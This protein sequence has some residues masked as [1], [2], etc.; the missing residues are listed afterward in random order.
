MKTRQILNPL[1]YPRLAKAYFRHL[2]ALRR[3]LPETRMA[4]AEWPRWVLRRLLSPI[5]RIPFVLTSRSGIRH[6]LGDDVVDD[7]VFRHLHGHGTTLYFPPLGGEPEGIILDVGAHHGIY[8]MEALRRYPRCDLIAIE[9]D[10]AACR[11]IEANARLNDVSSR[12]EV[13]CAGLANDNG[14]GWLVVDEHGSW[15]SRTGPAEADLSS[16]APSGQ[17]RT[18]VA[19]K[20]LE[21]ILGG[22]E[23]AIVKCNAEG[24]EFA[25]I[26]QL[27]ALG[28]RPSVIVL[29]VHPEA[30][31]AQEL[32]SLLA[33]AGYHVSDA[34]HP[35]RGFRFHCFFRRSGSV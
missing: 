3:Q 8:A 9:P 2:R 18:E 35:P 16:R 34:D 10:P 21:A 12:I 30:G 1:A 14:R 7:S 20:T 15:A 24:A 31:F 28:H 11:Q 22:R 5:Y 13:V 19:L 26:P 6:A 29:M 17:P 27:I 33:G 23:P 4:S 25:L 32:V